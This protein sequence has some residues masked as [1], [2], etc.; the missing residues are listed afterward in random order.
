LGDL[1]FTK[2]DDMKKQHRNFISED[3]VDYERDKS[4][5]CIV[6]GKGFAEILKI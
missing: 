4:I 1:L 5:F 6:S 3:F 2:V